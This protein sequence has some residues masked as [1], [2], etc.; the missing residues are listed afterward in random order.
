[1]PRNHSFT[2]ST[3][4]GCVFVSC[5]AALDLLHWPT[6]FAVFTEPPP[7][8]P[9][10]VLPTFHSPMQLTLAAPPPPPIPLTAV[11]APSPATMLTR[12]KVDHLSMPS[13]FPPVLLGIPVQG[14]L[15]PFQ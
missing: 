13:V 10:P 2:R 5:N 1:M 14:W 6:R 7:P 8:L 9:L 12:K 4:A 11:S 3:S 15:I